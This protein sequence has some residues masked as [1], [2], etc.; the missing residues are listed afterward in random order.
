MIKLLQ[1]IIMVLLVKNKQIKQ[2]IIKFHTWYLFMENELSFDSGIY[3]GIDR[4][5]RISCFL[6]NDDL[7]KCQ[8]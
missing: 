2:H 8:L 4:S 7:Q 6:R 1:T 5:F 3:D